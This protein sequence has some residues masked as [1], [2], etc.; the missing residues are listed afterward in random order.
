[1]LK[2]HVGFKNTEATSNDCRVYKLIIAKEAFHGLASEL[3]LMGVSQKTIYPDLENHAIDMLNFPKARK[4]PNYNF[5]T[6][7]TKTYK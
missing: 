6:A 5:L 2:N 7:Y 3:R 1:M 4:I